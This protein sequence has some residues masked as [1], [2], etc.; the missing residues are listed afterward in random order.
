MV[1]LQ[2]RSA[3]AQCSSYDYELEIRKSLFTRSITMAP[4]RPTVE[5]SDHSGSSCKRLLTDIIT[6]GGFSR[7]NIY[8]GGHFSFN[9]P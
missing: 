4:W 5:H 6:V 9:F 7:D 8:Y 2:L 1:L 3:A